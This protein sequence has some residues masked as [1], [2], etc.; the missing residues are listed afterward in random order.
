MRVIV[1]VIIRIIAM[2][3]ILIIIRRQ[4]GDSAT[5]SSLKDNLVISGLEDL[6]AGLVVSCLNDVRG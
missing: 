6:S 4:R 1:I 2:I 3:L 5:L